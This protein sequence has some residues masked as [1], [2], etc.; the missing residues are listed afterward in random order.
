V[1]VKF[2]AEGIG[3]TRTEHMFFDADRIPAMREMIVADT[4]EQRKK[5]LNKLLPMQ[6][7]DF[8]GINEAMEGRPVTIRYLD[9]PLHEFL[10]KEDEDMI[11][12]LQRAP[13]NNFSL[14][15][16]RGVKV[17]L[18]ILTKGKVRL[19]FSVDRKNRLRRHGFVVVHRRRLPKREQHLPAQD[20]SGQL[21]K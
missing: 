21:I 10:P 16:L 9:P 3:L 7:S 6:K 18:I 19:R 12:E 13:I 14:F 15:D 4:V 5:A 20:L 1:A 2:G 11:K 17:L 8:K